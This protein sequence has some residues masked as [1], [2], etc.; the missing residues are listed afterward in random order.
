M[1]V[2]IND[3]SGVANYPVQMGYTVALI[4]L[5]DPKDG[6][7]YI[8]AVETNGMPIATRVFKVEDITPAKDGDGVSR[9]EYDDLKAKYDD[10]STQMQQ[11]ILRLNE[12]ANADG[13]GAKNK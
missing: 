5:S 10:L 12:S 7:M 4:N 11:L 13:K 2:F 9:K 6:R 1:V 8:K 3:D